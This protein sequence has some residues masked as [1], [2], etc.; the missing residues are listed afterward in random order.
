MRPVDVIRFLTEVIAFVVLGIW[1]FTQFAFPWPALLTGIGAP[2]LAIIVWGL[3]RSPRAV[4]AID[5]F[6]KA[7]IEIAIF[8]SATLAMVFMGWPW[9]IAVAYVVLATV[10]GVIT[11]RRD[12]R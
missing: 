7:L 2:L 9:W 3:F 1:G 10:T 12:L 5:T 6:G 11:G 4:F 8:S